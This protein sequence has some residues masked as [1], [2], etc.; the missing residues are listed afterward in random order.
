M[1][2][3]GRC[4]RST[5]QGQKH[6]IRVGF[7]LHSMGVAGA[8][9][10][11]TA[12]IRRLGD[13]IEPVVYCLDAIGALG[14]QLL[15]E[16]VP[17]VLLGRR[18]GRDLRVAWRLANAI[19][20]RGTEV[21][22]AHQYT[23]FFYAAL[24]RVLAGGA[25]RLLFTEHGRHYPD[26]VAPLRRALNRL[27]LAQLAN[28]INACS[29]FSARSLVTQDGFPGR[30]VGVIA[31]GID[32]SRYAPAADRAAERV[33]VGLDPARRYVAHV[34]RLH[35]IKDQATLL[36]GF[37]AVAT[38][39]AD[40]DLLLAGDG[41]LR[42]DLEK[43][44]A[45]LGIAPRV[46]FLG[47]RDDVPELLRASDVFV[48]TSLSEA[49]PLTLLEAMATGLP[50]VVTRVGGCGE[51]LRD[52]VEGLLVPRRDPGALGAALLALL[53]D[54]ARAQALGSAGLR[55]VREHYRIEQTV[56]EYGALYGCCPLTQVQE[57]CDVSYSHPGTP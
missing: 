4:T 18:P 38:A 30:R 21:L 35:P 37:Q 44:A 11:V 13:R 5:G 52:G 56:E 41:P 19:R 24:A 28:A 49:A 31:N 48:L 32:V 33:R 54:P 43:L 57:S 50:A 34:A 12:T 8:E 1:T 39:R 45:D 20:H 17:V 27:V 46:R 40:V 16:G 7:V 47:G 22:H 6:P 2:A 55:R 29:T 51:I 14:E 25:P 3:A 23:P 9:V 15:R 42:V 36:R 10:L 53:D 26:Q